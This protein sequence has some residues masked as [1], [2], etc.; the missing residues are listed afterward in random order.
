MATTDALDALASV[1]SLEKQWNCQHILREETTR[2][3]SPPR[4]S[5]FVGVDMEYRAV[6]VLDQEFFKGHVQKIHKL[7]E[8]ADPFIKKRLL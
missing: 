4:T 2:G 7:A 8:N 6:A 1:S 5:G 3:N